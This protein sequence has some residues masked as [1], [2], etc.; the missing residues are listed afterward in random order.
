[1]LAI[2]IDTIYP[3]IMIR[4]SPR[5]L[6]LRPRTWGGRREG[7][8]RKPLP[9][10]KRR[11]SHLARERFESATPVH[12]TLRVAHYVWNLRSAR[13]F[14]LIVRAFAAPRGRHHLRLIEFTVR[15]NNL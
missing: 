2:S 12:V 6:E 1:M 3:K 8:G 14:R 13:T 4:G 15:G 9:E 10:G 7:A 5:Q 11:V